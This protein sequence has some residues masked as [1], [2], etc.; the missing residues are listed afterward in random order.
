MFQTN[1]ISSGYLG[2]GLVERFDLLY[3]DRCNSES[4]TR[5]LI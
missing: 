1:R 3:T 2:W 5:L 4:F